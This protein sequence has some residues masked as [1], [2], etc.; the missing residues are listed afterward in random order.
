[1][2][3]LIFTYILRKCMAQGAKS[4]VKYLVR[5]RCAEGF[6]SGVKGLKDWVIIQQ[7]SFG[8]KIYIAIHCDCGV[9]VGMTCT[10]QSPVQTSIVTF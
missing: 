8:S 6:N 7:S 1:M 9:R 4:S 5:Q 3:W 2:Y 10:A